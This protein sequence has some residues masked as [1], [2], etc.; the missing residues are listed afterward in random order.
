MHAEILDPH[1]LYDIAPKLWTYTIGD[2][3]ISICSCDIDFPVEFKYICP[4]Q[5]I[6]KNN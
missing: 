2:Y 1:S 3:K 6:E 5:L 4:G